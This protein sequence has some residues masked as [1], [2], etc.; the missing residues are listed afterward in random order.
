MSKVDTSSKKVS[1]NK[2]IFDIPTYTNFGNI[3][4]GD[5]YKELPFQDYI[6]NKSELPNGDQVFDI[7]NYGAIGDGLTLDTEAFQRTIEAC[8]KAGGGTVLVKKG[9]YCMGTVFLED[10]ITL[11]I[12]SDAIILASR[13]CT[14]YDGALIRACGKANVT[15]TGSGKIVGN[16]E[17]F[18]YEPRLKPL[19][20]PLDVSYLAKRGTSDL[21]LPTNTLRY[22]YRSRIR[23]AE[24][25]YKEGIPDIPRPDYMVWFEKCTNVK[26]YN[27][28]LENA[29]AWTLNL[30]TCDEVEI[31]DMV[32][33][34]NRHV[35]N[36]DGID[37][38]GSNNVK[39]KHCFISTADDGIVLKNPKHTGRNMKNINISNCKILS[40]MNA[41]KIGTETYYDI[42]DVVVENCHFELPDIYPGT[43]SGISIESADGSCVKNIMVRNITMNKVTCPIFICLNMRNREEVPYS[44]DENSKYWGG[45]IEGIH[46]E[47]IRATNVEVPSIITGFVNKK[48]NTGFVRKVIK[49]VTI[50]HLDIVYKNNEE[51]LHIPQKIDEYLV[52]YPENN[53]FGD[54]NAYGLYIQHGE[55]VILED[56][57]IVPRELNSRECV[58]FEPIL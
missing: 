38:T 23:F 52:E 48:E 44:D 22:N 41:F 47:N 4:E 14:N 21:E 50:S 45:Q 3:Y 16:G 58:V 30:D 32:I 13:D 1:E 54:V 42:T 33:N 51:I 46:L 27:I 7:K 29:M 35:A 57:K 17:W 25:K 11:F 26:V 20:K 2:N 36:T 31:F 55:H 56:I 6:N 10:D 34:N 43:V 5:Y 15:I 18:V 19:L 40:V 12:A 53:N 8:S 24:D 49:N 37:V 39:I 9:S 28:V